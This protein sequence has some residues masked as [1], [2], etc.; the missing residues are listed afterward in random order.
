MEEIANAEV[1]SC[2]NYYPTEF[3]DG[4]ESYETCTVSHPLIPTV[5]II[6]HSLTTLT[7]YATFVI[8]PIQHCCQSL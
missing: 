5:L 3:V 1:A 6:H 7:A 2:D 8:K 4:V